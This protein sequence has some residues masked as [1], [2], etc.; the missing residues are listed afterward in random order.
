[1]NRIAF[2]R[3]IILKYVDAVT[4]DETVDTPLTFIKMDI[5]GAEMNAIRGGMSNSPKSSEVGDMCLS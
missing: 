2:I 4:I 5:E 1:M 3:K